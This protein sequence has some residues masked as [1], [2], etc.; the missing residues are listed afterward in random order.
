MSKSLATARY[1]IHLASSEPEG[2][3]LTHL[4]LQKL[5]YYVQGYSLALRGEAAFDSPIEAWKNGPVVRDVWPTFKQ[6]RNSPIPEQEGD[7]G[8]GLAPEDRQL[9][10]AV[11]QHHRQFSGSELWRKTHSERPWRETRG[12]LPDTAHGEDEIPDSLMADFF[13]QEYDRNCLRGFELE[14]VNAALADV[15]LG[16]LVS[17]EQVADELGIELSS[18][19]DL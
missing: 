6:Y 15:R 1:L 7:A 19:D 16:N 11:W 5:L 8:G 3:F 4:Q 9:V 17:L 14:H 12:G 2:N 13:K 18:V 10:D